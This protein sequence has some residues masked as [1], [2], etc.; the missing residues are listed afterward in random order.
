MVGADR[1]EWTLFGVGR[2]R[3]STTAYLAAV[4]AAANQLRSDCEVSTV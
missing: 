4:V 3:N 2:H 1:V